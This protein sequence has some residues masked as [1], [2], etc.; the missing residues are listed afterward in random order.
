[1]PAIPTQ[2]SSPREPPSDGAE[3]H[4]NA[5][6]NNYRKSSRQAITDEF[7]LFTPGRFGRIDGHAIELLV[8]MRSEQIIVAC[9]ASAREN[10]GGDYKDQDQLRNRELE[11]HEFL[12]LAQANHTLNQN[13][14]QAMRSTLSPNAAVQRPRAAV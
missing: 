6:D 5:K 9:L 4:N 1:M 12:R 2:E 3:D 11:P 8:Q 10:Q 7:G 13:H 14:A